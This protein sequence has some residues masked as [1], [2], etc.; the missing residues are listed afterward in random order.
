MDSSTLLVV[1]AVAIAVMGAVWFGL[2]FWLASTRPADIEEVDTP[3]IDRLNREAL[4]RGSGEEEG[5]DE[6]DEDNGEPSDDEEESEG[7]DDDEP[8]EALKDV[9]PADPAK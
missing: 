2:R 9:V 7:D 8:P 4:E 6:E 3:T 5:D 1:A